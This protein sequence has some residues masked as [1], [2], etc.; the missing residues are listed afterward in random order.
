MGIVKHI[1]FPF[2]D[3]IVGQNINPGVDITT[4][5]GLARTNGFGSSIGASYT[6]GAFSSKTNSYTLKPP[7]DWKKNIALTYPPIVELIKDVWNH[8]STAFV[9]PLAQ[10]KSGWWTSVTASVHAGGTF[11]CDLELSPCS[12]NW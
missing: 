6:F 4:S 1:I 11:V 12:Y 9:N 5:I 10:I 8:D 7:K 3:L 2:K